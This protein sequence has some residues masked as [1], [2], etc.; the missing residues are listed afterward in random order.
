[1][2]MKKQDK[3]IGLVC[4]NESL[5]QELFNVIVK[6]LDSYNQ[7]TNYHI[8]SFNQTVKTNYDYIIYIES[9]VG[10]QINNLRYTLLH[11]N[12]ILILNNDI[13]ETNAFNNLS[14]IIS[15]GSNYDSEYLINNISL[16][17]TITLFNLNHNLIQ[18]PFYYNSNSEEYIYYIVPVIIFLLNENYNLIDIKKALQKIK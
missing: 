10:F 7:F 16:N 6:N 17:S 8:I 3:Y 14:N 5:F 11:S 9:F 4:Q 2:R 15:Y 1:M 12:S 18:Y 13:G